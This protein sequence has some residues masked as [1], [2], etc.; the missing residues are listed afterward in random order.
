MSEQGRNAG[1]PF[2][3]PRGV[4]ERPLVELALVFF[5]L[6]LAS[7]L[8]LG[9]SQISLSS[10]RYHLA[11]LAVN[12]PKAA[13]LLYIIAVSDGLGPFGLGGLRPKD[14]VRGLL[15]AL[16]AATVII[17]PGLLFSAFGI[18]NSFLVQARSGPRASASLIPLFL[19]SSMSTGYCEELFFR[20]Y[21]LRRLGQVGLPPKWAAIVSALIFG[22]GH[23]YQGPVGLVSASLLGLFFA[24]RWLDAKNIHEIA[25]GHGL[26]D[27]AVFAI[28][29]YS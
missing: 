4:P 26:F 16:G 28:A 24:W 3:A 8:F 29:L 15:C 6:Y 10:T 19:A 9:P 17:V 22:L 27:A 1:T 20:S 18:E 12:L 2:G 5:A 13:F 23:G 14:V 25:F 21:L 7:Y 11:V